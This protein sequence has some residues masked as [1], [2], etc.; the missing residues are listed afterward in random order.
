MGSDFTATLA[1]KWK[2]PSITVS[3]RFL[4]N[5]SWKRSLPVSV[6]AGGQQRRL[7]RDCGEPSR[8]VVLGI[9]KGSLTPQSSW[10][11]EHWIVIPDC[12]L[13]SHGL[14]VWAPG[15][16]CL[17]LVPSLLP[18]KDSNPAPTTQ[19]NRRKH[20]LTE[21]TNPYVTV[22]ILSGSLNGGGKGS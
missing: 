7:R 2:S 19:D 14:G 17:N 5:H 6:C 9:P 12:I 16:H 1:E 20:A 15:S 8:E 22:D 3:S 13:L 10:G 4:H 21:S 11:P 18:N